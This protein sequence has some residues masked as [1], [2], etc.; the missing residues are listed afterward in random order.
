[1]VSFSDGPLLRTLYH[2]DKLSEYPIIRLI[3][4]HGF[5]FRDIFTSH[6]QIQPHASFLSFS[7]RITEFAGEVSRVSPLAPSLTDV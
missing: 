2:A 7:F 3:Q 1:M 5:T 4:F 6:R